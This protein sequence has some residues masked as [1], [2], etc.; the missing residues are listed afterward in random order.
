MKEI[1]GELSEEFN[2][3][4]VETGLEKILKAEK[5]DMEK[6]KEK[7]ESCKLSTETGTRGGG[8]TTVESFRM[9]HSG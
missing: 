8:R 4:L 9:R 5:E 7:M 6:M 3:M 1:R 2:S